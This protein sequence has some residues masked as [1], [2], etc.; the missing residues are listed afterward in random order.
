MLTERW[1]QAAIRVRPD[2]SFICL[3]ML[4]MSTDPN[5]PRIF[6]QRTTKTILA[7][8]RSRLGRYT[9]Y[10][11]DLVKGILGF[12]EKGVPVGTI[13]NFLDPACR[14]K[15][16]KSYKLLTI[17]GF[18]YSADISIQEFRN[19]MNQKRTQPQRLSHDP[20]LFE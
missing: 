17:M 1:V 18:N 3:L 20:Q 12:Y 9:E 4:Y 13:Y 7:H 2:N 15:A 19:V 16:E 11:N 14:H 10:N 5:A 8:V 6:D